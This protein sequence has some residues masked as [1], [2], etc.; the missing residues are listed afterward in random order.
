MFTTPD[1][2]KAVGSVHDTSRP[3]VPSSTIELM[4]AGQFW[5]IGGVVS[6]DGRRNDR[7]ENGKS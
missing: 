7:D 6:S 4:F 1:A 5:I 3:G 2:S